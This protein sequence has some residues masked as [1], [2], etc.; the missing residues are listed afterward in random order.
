MLNFVFRKLL[1][2]KWMTISLLIGNILLI[3]IAAASPMYSQGVL[4]RTLTRN[5]S[6]YLEEENEYPG[7]IHAE[8]SIYQNSNRAAELPLLAST[9]EALNQM[10]T[11]IGVHEK[12]LGYVSNP[13]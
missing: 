7:A 12:Y 2:K 8:Y 6:S 4:Q 11:D 13:H 10:V 3:A 9:E 1:S 5:L